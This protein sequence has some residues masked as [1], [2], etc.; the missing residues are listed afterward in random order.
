MTVTTI[1]TMMKMLKMTVIVS[2]SVSYD[3]D[4]FEIVAKVDGNNCLKI[5]TTMKTLKVNLVTNLP[6]GN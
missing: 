5:I 2:D 6:T 4:N 3:I 1:I